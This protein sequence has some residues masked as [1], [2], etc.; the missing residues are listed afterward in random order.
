[1]LNIPAHQDFERTET[2]FAGFLQGLSIGPMIVS[3][4]VAGNYQAC[5]I[6]APATVYE[7]RPPRWVLQQRQNLIDLLV[8]RFK[9]TGQPDP[10]ILHS[11][12]LHSSLL[13]RFTLQAFAQIEHCLNS[14]GSQFWD[15]FFL[16]LLAAIKV[17][18]DAIGTRIRLLREQG[19]SQKQHEA[20]FMQPI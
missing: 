17:V 15:V 20:K 3:D 2:L 5:A 12:G 13:P 14:H 18:V 19:R 1:M 16:R 9:G 4:S 8:S 11:G 7:D 6:G 10:H